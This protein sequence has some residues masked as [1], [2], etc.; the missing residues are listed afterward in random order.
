MSIRPKSFHN[1]KYI[2]IFSVFL[3]FFCA[4]ETAPGIDQDKF[5]EVYANYLIID[6]LSLPDTVRL[7]YQNKLLNDHAM[8]REDLR[9]SIAYFRKDP[10]RWVEILELLRDRI[11]ALKTTVPGDTLASGE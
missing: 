7:Q 10:E 9:Q 1:Y 6:E 5:I 2:L 11:K 8:T 3:G 4:R